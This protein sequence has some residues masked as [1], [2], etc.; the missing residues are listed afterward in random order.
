MKRPD[1]MYK[2]S[3][4]SMLASFADQVGKLG[5][6]DFVHG[7]LDGRARAGHDEDDKLANEPADG[8][9]QDAGRADLGV[10]EHAKE[11]SIAWQRFG[12]KGGDGLECEVAGANSSPSRDEN[13]INAGI[14][15]V[16]KEQRAH[17]VGLVGNNGS[18]ENA[19]ALQRRE[20]DDQSARSVGFEGAGV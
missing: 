9:A 18:L 8:S 10:A 3:D 6:N 7:K 15:G 19:M 5:Q 17:L 20:L 13:G 2:G 4:S 14:G 11:L 12:E 16:A 1:R